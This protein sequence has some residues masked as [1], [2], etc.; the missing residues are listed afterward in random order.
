MFD[1]DGDPRPSS[2]GCMPDIG[3]QE[4]L[5]CEPEPTTIVVLSSEIP[6]E[7]SLEQNYPNPFNPGTTIE[8]ALPTPGHVVLSIF[9]VLGEKVANLVSENLTA[10]KY[11]YE[12]NATELTSGI[13]FYKLKAVPIG[14]QAGSF[15]EIKKMILLK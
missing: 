12:W 7:F 3:A 8:F 5:L 13:Y 11:K 2:P 1:F 6:D 10:G 14:S 15:V 4:S 9:N